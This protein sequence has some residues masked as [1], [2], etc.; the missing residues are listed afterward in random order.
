[1]CT[2]LWAVGKI[3]GRGHIS[4]LRKVS[5]ELK[6]NRKLRIEV[7]DVKSFYAEATEN[8]PWIGIFEL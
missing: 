5:E 6:V 8:K 2:L 1:M 3:W 4:Y 7:F